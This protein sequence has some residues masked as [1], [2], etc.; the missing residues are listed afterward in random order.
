MDKLLRYLN[1]LTKD[2]R[3]QFCAACGTS[4]GYLRKACSVRQ[5]ISADLCIRIERETGRTVICED[6]RPD[7]DWAFIRTGAVREA[8][9]DSMTPA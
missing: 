9:L 6:M 4:E 5:T 2:E 1:A 3:S 8:I 7:V